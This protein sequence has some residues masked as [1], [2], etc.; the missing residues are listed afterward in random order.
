MWSVELVI[1]CVG[2]QKK[3]KVVQ[4]FVICDWFW[5]FLAPRKVILGEEREARGREGKETVVG[6]GWTQRVDGHGG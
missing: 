2:A 5:E 3:M 4:I 6:R 1:A